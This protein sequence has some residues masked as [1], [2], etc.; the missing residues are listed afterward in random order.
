ML[1]VFSSMLSVFYSM[2][3]VF[4]SMLSVFSSMLSVFSSML[5]VLVPAGCSVTIKKSTKH[6]IS[7]TVTKSMRYG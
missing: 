3:S 6:C 1:S 2:L 7:V 5:S 4:S